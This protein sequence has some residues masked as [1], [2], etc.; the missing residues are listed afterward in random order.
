MPVAVGFREILAKTDRLG[1]SL[2]V[3]EAQSEEARVLEGL[4]ARRR[5]IIQM[6]TAEQL[7]SRLA[8]PAVRQSIDEVIAFL[9][10]QEGVE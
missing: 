8:L 2:E 9:N 10:G 3:N 5:Q 1:L 6:R 4:V 7:R